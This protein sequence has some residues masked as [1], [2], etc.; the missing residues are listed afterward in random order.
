MDPETLET[1]G[2]ETFDGQLESATFTAHPKIDV[3]TGEMI[4]FG[5]EAKGL[6]TNDICYFQIGPD[7]VFTDTVWFK[8]PRLGMIH[9]FAV[10]Q[11]WV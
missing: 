5:Y 9:D 8:Q 7:G 6:A 10:T 2:V 11:N 4:T 3:K 1:I